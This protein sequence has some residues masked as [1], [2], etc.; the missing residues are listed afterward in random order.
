MLKGSLS[1]ESYYTT[2]CVLRALSADAPGLTLL[3]SSP[4]PSFPSPPLPSPPSPPLPFPPLLPTQVDSQGRELAERQMDNSCCHNQLK[5]PAAAEC[6]G[7]GGGEERVEQRHHRWLTS[8]A[9]SQR[10]VGGA[11]CG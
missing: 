4:L 7:V 8:G 6:S 10:K 1:G 2:W 5:L 3:P 11:V 9:D